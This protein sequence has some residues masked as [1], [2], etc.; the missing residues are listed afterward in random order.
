MSSKV[1]M[2]PRSYNALRKEVFR[3]KGMRPELAQAIEVARALGDLKENADYDAAKEKSGMT[4]AKIRDIDHKLSNAQVIDPRQNP[5]PEKVTFGVSVKIVD[6]ESNEKR[7]MM[8]VGAD[9]SNVEK[10]LISFES[11]IGKSLIG[12]SIGDI[13]TINL[14]S[15]KKE[16]EILE[17]FLE[18]TEE[19]VEQDS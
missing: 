16:Y 19:A 8:L 13:A 7:I 9:E 1:P 18:Y 11:P 6:V 17:I 2:T 10:G 3:L 15:G 14:P 5:E 12:K 4:E